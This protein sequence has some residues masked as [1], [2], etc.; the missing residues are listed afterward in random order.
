MEEATTQ[1]QGTHE[2]PPPW[3]HP[4]QLPLLTE[5]Q[6]TNS[7]TG[8]KPRSR[9]KRKCLFGPKRPH[10]TTREGHLSDAQE[11]EGLLREIDIT[12]QIHEPNTKTQ[13]NNTAN[14]SHL[15]PTSRP[16]ER[17]TFGPRRQ[18]GQHAHKYE[19]STSDPLQDDARH[20]HQELREAPDSEH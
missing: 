16:K 7:A 6:G 12:R 9:G 5:N 3:T 10:Q 13:Q 1:L 20:T 14:A 2:I 17:C 8:S 18:D 11:I 4:L 15:P 19:W